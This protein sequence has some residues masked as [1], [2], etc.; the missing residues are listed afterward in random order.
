MYPLCLC[1]SHITSFIFLSQTHHTG[2][3]LFSEV[4][5]PLCCPGFLWS[6]LLA[7]YWW[8]FT[9]GPVL[10]AVQWMLTSW[11]NYPEWELMKGKIPGGEVRAASCEAQGRLFS[12]MWALRVL[13]QRLESIYLVRTYPQRRPCE[14]QVVHRTCT[15][16][17]S[18]HTSVATF[19]EHQLCV[20]GRSAVLAGAVSF[21]PLSELGNLLEE[22]L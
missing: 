10:V 3:F 15:R 14:I 9:T 18:D 12:M 17:I 20:S 8:L 22:M 6:I 19:P 21:A 2:S 16:I 5:F 7:D 1:L 13:T 11:K 4:S